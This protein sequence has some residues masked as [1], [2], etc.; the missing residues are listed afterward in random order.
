MRLRDVEDEIIWSKN[1][2]LGRFTPHFG[3]KA[4]F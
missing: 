3:Y 4:M 1:N 2:S